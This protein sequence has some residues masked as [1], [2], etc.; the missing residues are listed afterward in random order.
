MTLLLQM[1]EQKH[2][3]PA[4]G[5]YRRPLSLSGILT[6]CALDSILK[7]WG[8]M[9]AQKFLFS[10]VGL[11]V[12][13]LGAVAETK[14]DDR[15]FEIRTYYANEGKLDSLLA[16]F[17][18][19]TIALFEKHGMENV[20]YWVPQENSENKLVYV[21]AFPSRKAS[22]QS[23]E[24]FIAD[25]EWKAAYQASIVD[26]Q[27]VDRIERSFMTMTA[28]S[29]ELK[30]VTSDPSR[31][32]ELRIYTT[33]EGRLPNLDA[34]FRDHT[35]GLFERHGME[36]LIYW[37][38]MDDQ[39]GAANTLVYLLAHASGEAARNSWNGFRSDPDWKSVFAASRDAAGGRLVV[40]GGVESVY[41]EP[42]D[43]SP[44]K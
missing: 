33:E 39:D 5:V 31:V 23:W 40:N 9:N 10:L 19:H 15:I 8:T 16:R 7:R 29:P 37:H 6:D 3:G 24:A 41:L 20:G 43:F 30:L 2:L 21:L 12:F 13:S 4:L 14:A 28:Y 11:M 34:R 36:N 25:P 22:E 32:F 27:L 38:L 17:R 44:M 42:V 18:D 26:G 1:Q 35:I